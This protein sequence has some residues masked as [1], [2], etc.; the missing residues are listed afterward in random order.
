MILHKVGTDFEVSVYG[1]SMHANI[2]KV[3]SKKVI[4]EYNFPK[5]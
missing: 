4:K 3:K 5:Y 1:K 2:Q